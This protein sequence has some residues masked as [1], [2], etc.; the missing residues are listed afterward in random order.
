MLQVYSALWMGGF[1]NHM[2]KGL[3]L[4]LSQS[5]GSLCPEHAQTEHVTIPYA[6]QLNNSLHGIGNAWGIKSTG[7][8]M[9]YRGEAEVPCKPQMALWE[10]LEPLPLRS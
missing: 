5:K 4:K 10:G 2:C 8:D 3:R 7:G 9:K 1:H 6:M